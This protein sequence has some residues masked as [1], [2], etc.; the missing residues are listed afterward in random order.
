M[1]IVAIL[2][3][4]FHGAER[5]QNGRPRVTKLFE[6]IKEA[7]EKA[8]LST[9]ELAEKLGVKRTQAWRLENDATTLSAARLFELA[10]LF[11][12]DP[13]ELFFGEGN[14]RPVHSYER[15]CKIVEM[16]EE[17]IQ[18]AKARPTPALVAEAVVEVLRQEEQKPLAQIKDGFDPEQYRGLVTLIF[19]GKS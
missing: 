15:V 12:V 8:G 13:R 1:M 7:R 9:G 6:R 5:L 2:A 10:D 19:K 18:Q 16:V 17:V 3:R 14:H 4:V 11:G